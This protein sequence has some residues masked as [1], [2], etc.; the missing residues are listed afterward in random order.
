MGSSESFEECSLSNSEFML[1]I[2]NDK[3]QLFKYN[4]FLDEGMGTDYGMDSSFSQIQFNL[5]FFSSS[6]RSGK[7]C[8][9]KSQWQKQ[10]C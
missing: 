5:D 3:L 1:F 6:E 10:F 7:K 2:D 4:I 8:Y 9:S